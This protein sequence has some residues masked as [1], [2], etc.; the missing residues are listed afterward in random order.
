MLFDLRGRRRRAVQATYLTLAVLMGGGLVFFGIG[1]DVSGGLFDAFS[2]R[3]GGDSGDSQLDERIDRL[4]DRLATS[5]D[6]AEQTLAQLVRLNY[7]AASAQT[8]SG[9]NAIPE[10]G[11]DELRAAARYWDRYVAETDGEPNPDLA[12]VALIVFDQGGLN[13]KDK[14]KEVVRVIAADANNTQTYLL[15]VQYAAAAGDT[16]T[17]DLAA[18][19][20]VD[21]AP[22]RLRKRVE[23]QAEQIKTQAQQQ[24]P[25]Q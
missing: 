8:P 12:R 2:D 7:Q 4:E 21:L 24:A 25:E 11:K 22:E 20:A 10:E 23:K 1:G 6:N 19:K 14:A 3:S 9:T 15:L 16:R 18:Q 13:Q 5:P 17:A